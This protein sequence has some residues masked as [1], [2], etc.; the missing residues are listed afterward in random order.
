MEEFHEAAMWAGAEVAG[1]GFQV[2][3]PALTQQAAQS[4]ASLRPQPVG[5]TPLLQELMGLFV[6]TS[7]VALGPHQRLTL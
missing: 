5:H 6:C 1:M 3:R 2:P 7:L 4:Q